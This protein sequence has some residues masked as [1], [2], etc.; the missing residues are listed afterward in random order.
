[1]LQDTGNPK[2]GRRERALLGLLA[3]IGGRGVEASGELLDATR[4]LDRELRQ[5]VR[6]WLKA[7]KEEHLPRVANPEPHPTA[8]HAEP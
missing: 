8:G 1:M 5:I 3:K 2:I 4:S 7:G 6:R